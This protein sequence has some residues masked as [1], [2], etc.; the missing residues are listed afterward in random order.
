VAAEAR[1]ESQE[2]VLVGGFDECD[3]DVVGALAEIAQRNGAQAVS[4]VGAELVEQ[5][6][7]GVVEKCR[8]RDRKAAELGEVRREEL[9]VDEAELDEIR[10]KPAAVQ[11]LVAQCGLELREPDR[12]VA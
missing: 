3:R 8:C 12:G 5:S 6:L 7:V 4:L 9:E 11:H 10:A 1:L 2:R